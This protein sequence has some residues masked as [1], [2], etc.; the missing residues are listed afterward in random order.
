MEQQISALRAEFQA[1]EAEVR[2]LLGE[3]KM[4]DRKRRLDR[5]STR[6]LR[7]A[8]PAGKGNSGQAVHR[9]SG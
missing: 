6:K 1:Y 7:R 4:G 5:T 8:D 9:G 2:Q 3:E